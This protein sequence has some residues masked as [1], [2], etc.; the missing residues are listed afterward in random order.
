MLDE[1]HFS[2]TLQNFHVFGISK[3]HEYKFFLC[4][5][6]HTDFFLFL[7]EFD[8]WVKT[9]PDIDAN[10]D[11]KKNLMDLFSSM[12]NLAKEIG[13]N[14]PASSNSAALMVNDGESK[15]RVSTCSGYS[16]FTGKF[17]KLDFS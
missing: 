1:V 8:V 10:V 12:E 7:N 16:I 14:G 13:E 3:T 17:K 4:Y 6:L 2:R 9:R 15:R 5:T 11:L